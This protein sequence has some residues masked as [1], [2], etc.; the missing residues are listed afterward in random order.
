MLLLFGFALLVLAAAMVVLFAM[1]GELSSRVPEPGATQRDTTVR[2]VEEARIG[3][4][5]GVW[6][7]GLPDPAGADLLVLSTACGSCKRVAEQLRADPAHA[8]WPELAVVVSTAGRQTGEDFVAAHGLDRFPHYVDEAGEWTL[9]EF[10]V[11]ISPTAL[12]F[13]SGKLTSAYVFN[14][15]AALRK[16]TENTEELIE[17]NIGKPFETAEIREQTKEVV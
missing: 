17:E 9:G 8:A 4:A 7:E 3:H 14:D 12:V 10:G 2:P 16:A 11:Q 6:P 15:V 13:R 5:P 1:M